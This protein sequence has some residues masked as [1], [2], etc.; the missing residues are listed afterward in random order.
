MNPIRDSNK[1]I[2]CFKYAHRFQVGTYGFQTD[3]FGQNKIYPKFIEVTS[4]QSILEDAH[5]LPTAQ[6]QIIRPM[7]LP[8]LQISKW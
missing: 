1:H 7:T 8:S 2:T 5:I 4:Y 6:C 3:V